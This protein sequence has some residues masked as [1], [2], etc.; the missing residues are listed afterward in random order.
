MSVKQN[1]HVRPRLT[2]KS[3]LESVMAGCVAV[4]SIDLMLFPIDSTKTRMQATSNKV[5]F[6]KKAQTVSKFKGLATAMAGSFPCA[7]TFWFSYELGKH[8]LHT[9]VQINK[10][11]NIHFQH[12]L[13]SCM[14]EF[15]TAVV[16]SPFEVV[17]QNM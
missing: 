2:V 3:G 7:G 6:V 13:A 10:Y 4:L 16:R 5:D 12:L 15:C 9:S 14:A 11:T 1:P 8:T 17:K